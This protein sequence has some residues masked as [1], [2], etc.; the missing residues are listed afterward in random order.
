MTKTFQKEK[1]RHKVRRDKAIT[2]YYNRM[3]GN[4]ISKQDQ[5]QDRAKK[6]NQGQAAKKTKKILQKEKTRT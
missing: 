1:D 6:T 2:K 5:D 4:C 3:Q